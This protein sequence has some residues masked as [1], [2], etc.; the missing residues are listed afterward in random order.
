M[1]KVYRE[2]SAKEWERGKPALTSLT[3]VARPAPFQQWKSPAGIARK[4]ISGDADRSR[5]RIPH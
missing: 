1:E 4:G 3:L 5:W 2:R